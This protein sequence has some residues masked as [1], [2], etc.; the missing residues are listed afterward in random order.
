MILQ[1]L[2]A[3]L[4]GILTI[5]A[6]CILP[7]LPILLGASVGQ[8]SKKR[9]LF[10]VLGFVISFSLAA[11]ALSAIIQHLG[12]QPS[13]LRNIAVFALGLF[14][15]LMI[16][17]KPFEILSL[18]LSGTINKASQAS[19]GQGNLSGFILGVT[20]GLIWTPCA[21]PVLGSILTLVAT[22]GNTAAAA[23]LLIA[24]ALG[25][26]LPMLVIAYGS[27]VITTK[28]RAIAHYSTRL[29]QIFG[30]LIILLAAAMYFQYDVV[31]ENALLAYCPAVSSPFEQNL[32]NVAGLGVSE[33]NKNQ[34]TGTGV[35]PKS[36]M[37]D[38]PKKTEFIKLQNYGPAPEFTG[39]AKWLN[40]PPN[41]TQ[42]SLK[43]LKGKVVLVDF[44]TYS[45]IN[46]IRT[47]PYVTKWYDQYKDKGL[48]VVG[49]HTP[50]FAF[51]QETK[52]VE[53]AI[54]KF[55][56]H[57]P[58]AQDNTYSTWQAYNNHYWPAEYLIDQNGNIVYEHF[59]EGEYDHTENAIRQLLEFDSAVGKDDGVDLS[60]INSPEMYFEPSRLENLSPSQSPSQSPK[61][62]SLPENLALNNFA[63]NGKW[64]FT[65]DHAELVEGE[66]IIRLNYNSKNV[67]MV[68]SSKNPVTVTIKLDGKKTGEVT[69]ESAKLY[70]LIKSS[71]PGQHTLEIIIPSPGFEAFTFTFG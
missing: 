57:Y 16:W 52:N 69:I 17:P 31:I 45:C 34:V 42:L 28:V 32:A 39:I 1:I 60:G 29:Q 7:M 51:E 49:V 21:G 71:T 61:D 38:Y 56:I 15:I 2:F 8:Q 59:G 33:I 14:G 22:Q 40:L 30:V 36:D 24:Y 62:Y 46:C 20:L 43:D 41:Q 48:V 10:I 44:W 67:F 23:I 64:Q 65:Q 9:P 11:L 25:A 58:V 6:P 54:K 50:E 55:N 18:K 5:A 70:D 53:D 35:L 3:I 37:A 19:S 12:I 68:A 47:L 26:G 4:A 27:Q 66:G 63:L 13:T